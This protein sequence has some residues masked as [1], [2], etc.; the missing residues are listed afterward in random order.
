M[1]A[2]VLRTIGAVAAVR[3]VVIAVPA[4]M[5]KS[6]RLEVS[7]AELQIPAKII[8]GGVERQDSV[9]LALSLTSSEAELV[10]VHDAARP[11]AA[12]A[13][14]EACITAA[15]RSGGAIVAVPVADT[16]KL[17]EH[18]RVSA[19]LPRAG[20][21]QAQTPQVFR[22]ELLIR[23]HEQASREPTV[24]TD[25]AYL[26][27]RLGVSLAVVEG[28]NLNM[29]ITTPDDLTIAQAIARFGFPR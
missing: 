9:R 2:R 14:F 18:Q 8:Q 5:E 28:S 1:L 19:T 13:M 26:V 29:K 11:F 3:E 21:W 15:A 6:A 25:D 23:A 22:R 10:V 27:E 20:L 4:G 7:A 12:P 24:V 17:V 16:L